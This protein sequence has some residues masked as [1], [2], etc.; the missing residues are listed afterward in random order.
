MDTGSQ[1]M[2]DV[3]RALA[4]QHTEL[5]GITDGLDAE[6]WATPSL[7]AGWSVADVLLHMAQTGEMAVA[8]L[9][10]RFDDAVTIMAAGMGDA[11]EG[12]S[13]DD[14]ADL[15][16]RRER[17]APGA[18]V[19]ARWEATAEALEAALAEVDPH[20]RVTWVR[21]PVS[22]LSLATTRLAECWIHTGDIA[23]PLGVDRAPGERLRHVARLAWRTLPY[24]FAQA[25]RELSG[26]VAFRLVGPTGRE[27]GFE[28]ADGDAVTVVEG[29]GAD[30]CAVAARRVEPAATG[31][32]ATGPDADA[33][34][35]LVRTYA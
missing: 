8:T 17:G 3:R 32:R 4:E 15:A 11:G 12:L 34:L 21:G 19:A 29:P 2:V 31:L 7:C 28:P 14:A 9:D 6:A 1:T 30:L 24:A 16:V 23:E 18:D 20:R 26:P 5:R 35:D 22:A 25:G 10:G 13:V 27:W 33:V